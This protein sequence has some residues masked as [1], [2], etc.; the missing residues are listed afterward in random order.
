[1]VCAAPYAVVNEETMALISSPEPMP[2]EVI[3]ALL[4]VGA[5]VGV[6]LEELGGMTELIR[7]YVRALRCP[8]YR[9]H[10]LRL[11]QAAYQERSRTEG[12]GALIDYH[13]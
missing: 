13:A 4:L 8:I 1:V 10:P 6:L 3:K 12:L 11:K 7:I 2:V 9:Q 5:L